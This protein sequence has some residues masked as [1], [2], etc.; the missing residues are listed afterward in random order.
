MKQQK[1]KTQNYEEINQFI[2]QK[3]KIMEWWS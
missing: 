2:G 1:R 3:L